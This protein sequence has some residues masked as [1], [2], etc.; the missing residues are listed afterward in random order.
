MANFFGSFLGK[1]DKL[2]NNHPPSPPTDFSRYSSEYI[3]Y[4]I[5]HEQTICALEAGFRTN[6]AP[7][8]IAMQTL[9]T[10]CDFYGGDWA[11]V[12]ELDME[13]GVWIPGWWYNIDPTV[14][15]LQKMH[16]IENLFVMPNWVKAMKRN[17]AVVITDT[18]AAKDTSPQEYKVYRR[19]EAK[20][21]MGVPFGPAPAGFL[22]IRNPT[23]YTNHTSA[24][25]TFAY[26]LHRA[27][28]QSNASE[29][30]KMTFTPDNIQNDTDI[31][32]NFFGDMEI[33]I[34]NGVWR[35]RD[36]NSPKSSRVV[37][38]I[39]LHGK[40]AHSALAIA[41]ALYPEDSADTETINKNIRGYIYR[42][43]K[44]F[45]LI[46]NHKL[47]EY[48]PNGYR[49]NSKLHIM[50]DLQQFEMLWEQ[51]Q[52]N[53]PLTHKAYLLKLA[54]KLY[55]GPVCASSCDDHWLVGIAT[56]YKMKYI[57]MVNELLSIL[58]QC[59]DY[60]GVHHFALKSL[61]LAPEN[62]KAHYWL[63]HAKYHSGAVALAKQEIHR[64]KE[65]LTHEEFSIFKRYILRDTSLVRGQILEG[66]GAT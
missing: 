57:G 38:Y 29:R 24:L 10:V 66:F 32:I 20:S 27:I 55:R 44:S 8:D 56:D 41:D 16:D 1:R 26:I 58:A 3:A 14:T 30:T 21:V 63:V 18:A 7:K 22:L 39:L 23:K 45:G 47:I 35:E 34:L 42:F 40:A 4:C 11:G 64:V 61:R 28:V 49:V 50:T 25:Q 65:A 2:L 9:R 36:F 31:I 37:A 62:V 59:E 51:T 5:E 12:V 33:C 48:S 13:L 43:R 60:D 17:E 53:L 19:L 46:S 15:T 52:T 6:E 54:I